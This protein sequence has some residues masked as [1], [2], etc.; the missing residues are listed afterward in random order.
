MKKEAFG[1]LMLRLC[2]AFD[3]EPAKNKMELYYNLLKDLPYEAL[4]AGINNLIAETI[5]PKFPT[6]GAVRKYAVDVMF[7]GLSDEVS[8]WEQVRALIREH[9]RDFGCDAMLQMDPL[10]KETVLA[11]GWRD[12]CM[13]NN[14]DTCRAHYYQAYRK[15]LEEKVKQVLL[16]SRSVENPALNEAKAKLQ[17]AIKSI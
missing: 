10:T 5:Y 16:P 14:I 9:G 13:T 11:I 2:V 4:D 12:L 6:V 15:K 7:Q 17:E 8:S 1:T 3:T